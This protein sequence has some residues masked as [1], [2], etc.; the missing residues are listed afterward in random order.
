MSVQ[1]PSRAAPLPFQTQHGAPYEVAVA[2]SGRSINIMLHLDANGEPVQ[3]P[4][5]Q[6][7]FSVASGGQR[8]GPAPGL[9]RPHPGLSKSKSFSYYFAKRA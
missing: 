2:P 4:P 1:P 3:A 5:P 9:R 8:R 6:H 7:S